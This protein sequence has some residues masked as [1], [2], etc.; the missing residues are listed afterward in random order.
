MLGGIDTFCYWTE[1]DDA[2]VMQKERG[3]NRVGRATQSSRVAAETTPECKH[4][5]R[6]DLAR[7]SCKGRGDQ[8]SKETWTKSN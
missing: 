2:D 3:Q 4:G 5:D 1:P 7:V 8:G 6:A